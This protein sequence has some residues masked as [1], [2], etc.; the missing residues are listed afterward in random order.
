MNQLEA[1]LYAG[2]ILFEIFILLS[3][4]ERCTHARLLLSF[5]DATCVSDPLMCE[6]CAKAIE[7]IYNFIQRYLSVQESLLG[8]VRRN[9]CRVLE[10]KELLLISRRGVDTTQYSIHLKAEDYISRRPRLAGKAN[11]RGRARQLED[12]ATDPLEVSHSSS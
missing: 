10:L 11:P 3:L 8:H 12:L 5:Q 6:S 7:R 2:F 4:C 9:R 1:Y